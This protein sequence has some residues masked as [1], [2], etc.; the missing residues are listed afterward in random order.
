MPHDA[1][2]A[3]HVRGRIRV[4]LPKA[5]RD[6]ATLERV[7]RAISPMHGVKN[8]DVNP[9]TGSVV[10]HY[11]T[12]AHEDF[13]AALTRHAEENNLFMLA[14]PHIGEV[15]DIVE[16]VER[17]AEF[18]AERSETAK[19]IVDFFKG[20]NREVKKAT[21]NAVDLQ[22]LLPLGLAAYA[23]IGLEAEMATPLWVTLSLFSFNSFVSLHHPLPT[24][25]EMDRQEI[26]RTPG[27][28]KE[29][30]ASTTR[31]VIRKGGE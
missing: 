31:R 24:T 9:S 17:E 4:R 8:V 13:H 30:R 12:E 15:D 21:N 22:V 7:K 28:Q 2:V 25:M 26:V 19:T 18:L 11:D 27:P 20:L 23:F 1:H 3:H 14:P 29:T 10:V 5:K 16:T 6:H